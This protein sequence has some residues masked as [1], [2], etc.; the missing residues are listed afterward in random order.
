MFKKAVFLIMCVCLAVSVSGCALLVAGAIGGAGT[1]TW[2]SGKLS[3]EVAVSRDRAV[4]ASKKAMDALKLSITKETTKEDVVQLIGEYSD[5]RQ[6]WIDIR[7]LSPTSSKI[8]VRV[9]ATGDK[10]A[11]EKIMDKIRR[12]I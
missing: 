9:G 4:S 11:A 1:A 6:L 12:Y 3:Q 10:G 5:G 8:D 7:P 2:L